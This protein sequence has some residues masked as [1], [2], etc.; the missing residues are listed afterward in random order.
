[1]QLGLAKGQCQIQQI[2]TFTTYMRDTKKYNENFCWSQLVKLGAEVN[3]VNP[4]S[5]KI[6]CEHLLN[7]LSCNML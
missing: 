4:V 2:T 5:L 3:Q 7:L 1:M 6:L